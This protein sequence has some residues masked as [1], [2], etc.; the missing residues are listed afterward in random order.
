MSS[1]SSIHQ[2]PELQSLAKANGISIN[3]VSWEDSSRPNSQ[4]ITDMTLVVGN[5]E[6]PV[7]CKANTSDETVKLAINSF[8]V[9]VGNETGSP[10]RTIPFSEY[11]ANIGIYSGNLNLTSFLIEK[12]QVATSSQHC[13]LPDN[14]E[15][16]VKLYNHQTRDE[17]PA[18]LV[19]MAGE[20]GTSCQVLHGRGEELYFNQNGRAVKMSAKAEREESNSSVSSSSSSSIPSITPNT[21]FIFQIPLKQ[22]EVML[23]RGGF[24]GNFG[25]YPT[26]VKTRPQN[27]NQPSPP[28]RGLSQASLG[29]GKEQG[30]YQGTKGLR[31]TRDTSQAIRCTIQRYSV[32]D[33]ATLTASDIR[34]MADQIHQLLDTGDSF[35]KVV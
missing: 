14:S 1:L 13:I 7:I 26:V 28:P 24:F 15:F 8:S 18:V 20:Q 2:N 23:T 6:M 32:T 27:G 9:V 19:V 3:Y 29:L 4:N 33:E 11:L 17:D 30:V 21:L 5:L 16:A 31:L 12:E 25:N 10:L 22:K 35:V 34:S